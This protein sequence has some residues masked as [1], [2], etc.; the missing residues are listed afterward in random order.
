[1]GRAYDSMREIP[2]EELVEGTLMTPRG[3]MVSSAEVVRVLV[4]RLQAIQN[5]MEDKIDASGQLAAG[6]ELQA[7]VKANEESAESLSVKLEAMRV[8]HLALET[9]HNEQ[10]QVMDS[11]KEKQGELMEQLGQNSPATAAPQQL[12]SAKAVE[13]AV[14]QICKQN[15]E[16]EAQCARAEQQTQEQQQLLSSVQAAVE[17]KIEA[18]QQQAAAEAEK[19]QQNLVD[20]RGEMAVHAAGDSALD[21]DGLLDKMGEL[22][23]TCNQLEASVDRG[24]EQRAELQ[25]NLEQQQSAHEAWEQQVSDQLSTA[26]ASEAVLHE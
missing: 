3:S 26:E 6:V 5:Q 17:G 16:L 22:R 13:A 14:A 10:Q 4:G 21:K 15:K 7:Q 1:M 11:L 23:T 8:K 25:T 19:L 18:A 2:L 20:L 24:S 9:A 12:P